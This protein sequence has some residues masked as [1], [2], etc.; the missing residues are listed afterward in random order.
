[1]NKDGDPDERQAKQKV[2]GDFQGYALG[3]ITGNLSAM[4]FP[5]KPVEGKVRA[6]FALSLRADSLGL[7]SRLRERLINRIPAQKFARGVPDS[8]LH[9]TL[10]FLGE[11]YETM[12]P[13]FSDLLQS[14]TPMQPLVVELG[15]LVAFASPRH[16]RVVGVELLETTGELLRCVQE[17][18]RGTQRLGVAAES[19]SFVPH[20]TLL[21]LREPQ[22]LSHWL[23]SVRL[24]TAPIHFDALRLYQSELTPNGSTYHVLVQRLLG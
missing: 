22:N 18:E 17:L 10:K 4:P 14:C 21:R 16:T 13:D 12:V 2:K 20:I 6:F 24:E 3:D 8:S 1:L 9:V 19:R 5:S 11:I 15:S 23:E 7:L